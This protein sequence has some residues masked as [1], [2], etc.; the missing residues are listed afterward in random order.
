MKID[1][2]NVLVTGASRGLGRALSEALA[3]AGASVVMVARSEARLLSA[4]QSIRETGGDA[5][6][7]PADVGEPDSAARIAGMAAAMVG[8]IH[9]VVHNA[10]TLGPSPLKPLTETT[11]EEWERA[12]AVNLTGPFRLTRALV[13]SMVARGSG[14]V[15]HVSSDASV[16]A[17]P[18]WG[19]YGVSKAGLDH[20]SRIWAAE[21]EGSGVRTIAV[22]PGE[23]D[24]AM[25]AEALPEADPATL[26]SPREVA[27][28][29]VQRIA[30]SETG[31]G[32]RLAVAELEL[33][34]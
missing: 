15:L 2:L 16:E 24:T 5:H 34:P 23:M 20:L 10:S 32:V 28:R 6:A 7:L 22:D 14:L 12:L 4:V 8:P 33:R 21:L 13:G 29:I 17:Y 3:A 1:E 18:T 27:A 25:H 19:A 26:R 11:D 9:V 30:A 31:S